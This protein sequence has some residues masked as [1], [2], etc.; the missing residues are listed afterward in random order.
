MTPK[1]LSKSKT[2]FFEVRAMPS[3][4]FGVEFSEYV[5]R[6]WL[7]TYDTFEEAVRAYDV[8]AWHASRPRAEHNF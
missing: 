6:F 4:N 7:G 2:G 8:A 1:R 3:R 5:R